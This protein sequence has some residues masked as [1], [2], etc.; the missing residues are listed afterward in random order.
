MEIIEVRVINL[1]IYTSLLALVILIPLFL[2]TIGASLSGFLFKDLFIGNDH[3]D[4]WRTSIFF[5]DE[6]LL[7]HPPLWFLMHYTNIW[8]VNNSWCIFL[9]Y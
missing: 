4:F 7:K 3:Q 1:K 5:K 2:L 6:F 9:I 8:V